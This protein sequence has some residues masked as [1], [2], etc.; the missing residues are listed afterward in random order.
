M[1]LTMAEK[2][3]AFPPEECQRREELLGE[4]A[5][6][7]ADRRLADLQRALEDLEHLPPVAPDATRDRSRLAL[8]RAWTKNL[9][10]VFEDRAR[11]L[12][13]CIPAPTVRKGLGVSRQRL[14]QLVR[15]RRLVAL[16]IRERRSR[17]YPS[18]QF[19]T[20]GTI[21]AGLDEVIAAAHEAGMDAE[22][23]HFFMVEPHDR[24]GGMAPADLL[25]RGESAPVVRVLRLASLGL[26]E[27]I[28]VGDDYPT[29][30]A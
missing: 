16:L 20:E 26:D 14:H 21:V 1:S 29:C 15:E 11:L 4:F 8:L 24:L 28:S 12:D 3:L 9:V 19:T 2:L 22:T 10:R 17:L 5:A 6:L 23:L 13:E 18:W 30:Q 7:V 27:R 25:A